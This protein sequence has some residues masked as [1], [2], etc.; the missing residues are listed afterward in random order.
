MKKNTFR[1]L[2]TM[3]LLSLFFS[4][5][6]IIAA[7][8]P[9]VVEQGTRYYPLGLHLDYLEDKDN[10]VTIADVIGDSFSGR[11]I[12]VKKEKPNFGFTNSAYWIRI[13]L[14]YSPEVR[15]K[16]W[17]FELNYPLLDYI[18]IHIQ[19]PDGNI[20]ERETGDRFH[21]ENRDIKNCNFIFRLKP[22]GVEKQTIYFH[23]KSESSMLISAGLRDSESLISYLQDNFI[24]YGIFYGIL[25]I[26]VFYNLFLFLTVRD[27]N[28]FLYVI[29]VS[30]FI[31][32]RASLDGLGFQYLW[33]GFPW[34]ANKSALI[35]MGLTGTFMAVFCKSFLKTKENAPRLDKLLI[36]FITVCFITTAVSPWVKYS[37]AIQFEALLAALVSCLLLVAGYICLFRGYRPARYYVIAWTVLLVGLLTESLLRFGL[38][39][40]I[41]I[42]DHATMIGSLFEVVLLSFAMGDRINILKEENEKIQQIALD[43]Q[44]QMTLGFARFVPEEFFSF[45]NRKSIVDVKLG[46]QVLKEMTILFSDIRDFTTLSEKLSPQENF[47]FLNSFL[48]RVVPIIKNN[49][50]FIDKFIGDAIMALFPKSPSDAIN[51]AIEMQ[52]EIILYNSHRKSQNYDPISIGVGIHTGNLMLGTIGAEKRMET[53]VISDAVN[54]TARLEGLTKVFSSGILISGGCLKALKNTEDYDSRYLGVVKVK[55]KD[56]P[57]SVIEI[58]N[59]LP[60]EKFDLAVDAKEQFKRG[61]E[62]YHE[63]K[64]SKAHDV[65]KELKESNSDDKAIEIY[66]RRCEK[67][68]RDGTPENWDCVEQMHEK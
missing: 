28:Y 46:D 32:G 45:L 9:L 11:F 51:A 6:A 2:T 54:L 49:N 8:P 38:V 15:N 66:L 34:W 63:K 19:N 60:R 58:L 36:V 27:T 68:L 23:I 56:E 48:E 42:T 5:P 22:S 26:M 7:A 59:G 57:V 55:G 16:D 17:L 21:F 53:T 43:Q 25:L 31:L 64:I 61:V 33:P 52:E 47:N 39:P 50:G 65:F 29:Y 62:L 10:T 40:S 13:N 1:I 3:S 67:F 30:C 20:I 4:I 18:K 35:F 24:A 44:K 14:I 12:P 37:I 41:F